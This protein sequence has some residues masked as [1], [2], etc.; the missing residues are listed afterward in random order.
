MTGF[1]SLDSSRAPRFAMRTASPFAAPASVLG[2][3]TSTPPTHL[4][5]AQPSS[6]PVDPA[7]RIPLQTKLSIGAVNDPLEAEADA[8]SAH[9]ESTSTPAPSRQPATSVQ[10]VEAPPIVH[11]PHHSPGQP[12]DSA[13]RAR[14]EPR[15]GS[16]LGTV[17][18]H[19]GPQAA[20]SAQAVR[21]QAYT[22]GQ[23]IFFGAGRYNPGSSEGKRLLAHELSHTVQQSGGAGSRLSSSGRG[24]YRDP[25]P[26]NAPTG[27]TPTGTTTDT[28]TKKPKSDKVTVPVPPAFLQAL[29]LTPPSLLAPQ[30]PSLGHPGASLFQPPSQYSPTSPSILPPAAQYAP[31]TPTPLAPTGPAAP[32]LAPTGSGSGATSPT[33]APKAPDRVAFGSIGPVSIGARFGFP[34]LTQ[35]IKPGDPPSALQ[36]SLKKGEVLNF[37]VNH[38]PPSEYSVD[39]GKLVGALWGIFSTQIAPD[40]AAKIAAGLSSKPAGSGPSYQLDATI[41]LDLGGAKSGGGAGAT[42][43]VNF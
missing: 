20:E 19:T 14:M 22:V 1:S 34:D 12:V 37:I 23:D 6:I 15:F 41:L 25:L 17:R 26:P 31:T 30:Q 9:A 4:L 36:E 24:V 10:P 42:L 3:H 7:P 29:Q 13:I 5:P 33:A 32:S 18:I 8:M 27:T 28:D 43:T 2:A 16:D 21:A 35:D 11:Q 39:P 40:V 38:Q